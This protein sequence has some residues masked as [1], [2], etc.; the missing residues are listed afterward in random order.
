MDH[1][2]REHNGGVLTFILQPAG[3]LTSRRWKSL[4]INR[5]WSGSIMAF[6]ATAVMPAANYTTRLSFGNKCTKHKFWAGLLIQ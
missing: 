3:A 1:V 4:S 5:R 2:V 6:L